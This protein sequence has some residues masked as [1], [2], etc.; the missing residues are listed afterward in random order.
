MLLCLAW[1]LVLTVGLA[2]ASFDLLTMGIHTGD[3]SPQIATAGETITVTFSFTPSGFGPYFPAAFGCMAVGI[4]D[5][6]Q[7]MWWT[8]NNGTG[9]YQA[10]VVP[11]G[12]FDDNQVE[13]GVPALKTLTFTLPTVPPG[14]NSFTVGGILYGSDGSFAEVYSDPVFSTGAP[15]GT[16]A[17]ISIEENHPPYA[18]DVA[19]SNPEYAKLGQVLQGSYSYHDEENDP[20]SGTSFRWL[21]STST[22]P[23]GSYSAITGA[24]SQ[25]YTLQ[26]L[27]WDVLS[28]LRSLPGRQVDS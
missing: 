12:V 22:D 28:S 4:Y 21:R 10:A 20:E 27:I 17:Y 23:F 15:A 19:I 18:S 6:V 3:A 24:T 5:R 11:C 26:S 9:S 1:L 25:A 2:A 14:R 7:L 8:N 13:N 16:Y